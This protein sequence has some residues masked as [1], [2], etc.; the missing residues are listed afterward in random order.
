MSASRDGGRL[1]LTLTGARDPLPIV[2]RTPVPSAQIKS[3]VLLAGLAAPGETMVIETEASRDHT[4]R[5]LKHF[6]A[7]IVVE[8]TASIGRAHHAGRRARARRPRRSW[9]RPI[10]PRRRFPLVAALIVPGSEVILDGVMPNP[11]RTG[12]IITLREMGADIE[13]LDVRDDGGEEG[14]RISASRIGALRGRRG[15]ARAR[16][17]H[18]RRISGPGGGRAA[19]AGGHHA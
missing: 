4:E 18:D 1:P 14:G 16:A 13:A 3:A 19:F 9:C 6:G 10:H 11:L 5:M 8:P 17:V 12:L 2:Y 15:A 7:E